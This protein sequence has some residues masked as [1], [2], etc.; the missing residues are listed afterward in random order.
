[1]SSIQFTASTQTGRKLKPLVL[2]RAKDFLRDLD[3]Q[4]CELSISL[5]SDRRIRALNKQ[6][7]GKDKATDVLSFP[8]EDPQLLGDI[9]I[10]TDTAQRQAREYQRTLQQEVERYLAHGLL[11]LLGYDH[12][13]PRDRKKMAAAEQRLIGKAGMLGG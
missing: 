13:R 8:L 5:V 3:K 7:R 1:M 2:R 6:W 10:S 9:V 4:G 12:L 11:H